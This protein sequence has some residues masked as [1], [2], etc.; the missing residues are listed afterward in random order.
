MKKNTQVLRIKQ[1]LDEHGSISSME[2]IE[3]IGCTRLSARIA[4]MEHEGYVFRKESISCKNRY[5][6]KTHYTRYSIAEA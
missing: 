3:H 2:A 4:D 1:Y 6:D 5:G